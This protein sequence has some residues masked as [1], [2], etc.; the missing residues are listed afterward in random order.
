[1]KRILAFLLMLILIMTSAP[2]SYGQPQTLS[3]IAKSAILIDAKTGEILYE[4]NSHQPLYPASTTKMLTGILALE[5]LEMDELVPIDAETPFTEGSRIY[6]LEGEQINVRD[7]L[8]GLLLESAND[9]AV[10]LAK[11]ISGSVS[12]F[13]VLMNAKAQELGAI[14]SNFVNPNGLHDD[15]HLSTAYD[16]A[17][18]A[19][20]A[21]GNPVFRD[22]VSTYQYTVGATNMQEARY[23]YNTNRLL[24]DNINKVYVDGVLRGCKYDGVTGIKTG[25]TSKAGG[26]L[27]AG[28]KRGETELI[29]VVLGSSD[30]GRFS[31]SI[32]LLDYG[33]ANFKT[34]NIMK[35]GLPLGT[36]QVKRGTVRQVEVATGEESYATLPI[37]ASEHI[38]RTEVLLE[39]Y[40]QAPVKQGQK[41]GT[42]QIYAGE[43]LLGEFTAVALEDIE[44]GGMLSIVGIEDSTANIIRNIAFGIMVAMILALVLYILIK[45]RQIKRKKLL[46]QQLAEQA[47]KKKEQERARWEEQYKGG[48]SY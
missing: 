43:E 29:A 13:A 3:L 32:A 38:L 23:L 46:R 8:Y 16:M 36:V 26:C 37:E 12:D 25:Y 42:V 30:M 7:T 6:L 45:R 27:V 34:V 39:E 9:A 44:Q 4:M 5:N 18:I 10:A 2:V 21:M 28:A 48:R 31:D 14:N 33:F 41:A 24:Y 35:A 22:Y 20:Y 1:M 17:M 19:K 40:L 47:R 15:E 11:M